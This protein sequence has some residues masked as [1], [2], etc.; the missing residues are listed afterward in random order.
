MDLSC[1]TRGSRRRARS[2]LRN[3]RDLP[4]AR[5]GAL[6]LLFLCPSFKLFSE[7]SRSRQRCEH[8]GRARNRVAHDMSRPSTVVTARPRALL[9]ARL[10]AEIA[11]PLRE[12]RKL[13]ALRSR[14]AQAIVATSSRSSA[15]RAGARA[16]R[17]A[18]RLH[19]FERES[20]P[21]TAASRGVDIREALAHWT[22]ASTASAAHCAYRAG[23]CQS[24]RRSHLSLGGDHVEPVSAVVH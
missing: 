20:L 24:A 21:R 14:Q 9:T 2:S 18:R 13:T 3:A 15:S 10:S 5:A 6:P 4:T 16:V 19:P 1:R 8:C 23:A 12:G 22:A 11:A 7:R 17:P